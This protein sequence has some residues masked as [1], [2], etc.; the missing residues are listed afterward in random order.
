MMRFICLGSRLI[1]IPSRFLLC[2]YDAGASRGRE[3]SA[4]NPFW[5]KEKSALLPSRKKGKDS[6]HKGIGYGSEEYDGYDDYY[7]PPPLSY[8]GMGG[9]NGP[10]QPEPSI[11]YQANPNDKMLAQILSALAAILPSPNQQ[12]VPTDFDHTPPMTLSSVLR[13]SSILDDAAEILRNDSLED[14]ARR[15]QLYDALFEFLR[16]LSEGGATTQILHSTRSINKAGNDLLK[17]SYELP[18]RLQGEAPDTSAPLAECMSNLLDQSRGLLKAVRANQGGFQDTEDQ[19]MLILCTNIVD[20]GELVLKNTPNHPSDT[21]DSPSA[22]KPKDAWHKVHAAIAVPDAMITQHHYFAKEAE[23]LLNVTNLP[24]RRLARIYKE[25]TAFQTNLPPGIFVRYG[26]SRP[27]IMKI[28]IIGP[29]A[30]PYENGLFEF[31]LLCGLEYPNGAPKM[32]F[33]TTGVVE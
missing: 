5:L 10:K 33:K 14:A 25:V 1:T 6:S 30:T 23:E 24:S 15:S 28:V 16:A 22:T 8:Y 21:L 3:L 4:P 9:Y 18:T 27:D 11:S 26:E 2:G 29:K 32:Q 17:V 19:R 20:C 31:D 7:E 12:P 13:C